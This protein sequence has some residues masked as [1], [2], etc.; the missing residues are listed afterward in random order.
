MSGAISGAMSDAMSDEKIDN[1]QRIMHEHGFTMEIAQLLLDERTLV[2]VLS[3]MRK[4]NID[5]F[6]AFQV[7][8]NSDD[9]IDGILGD[10]FI[11]EA[12]DHSDPD[13]N[14]ESLIGGAIDPSGAVA[15][16]DG[17]IEKFNQ[18]IESE[19][20]S[21][22]EYDC[23]IAPLTEIIGNESILTQ[24]L[25]KNPQGFRDIYHEHFIQKKNAF[26]LVDDP[27]TSM[28]MEFV[29]RRWH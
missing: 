10:F 4:H 19:A 5:A 20:C 28:A 8:N 2:R 6:L 21:R 26:K 18:L 9:E 27:T 13:K 11:A 23:L 17:P 24:M 22:L 14:V 1:V 29:M 3:I 12:I 25:K 16:V 15:N 7:S